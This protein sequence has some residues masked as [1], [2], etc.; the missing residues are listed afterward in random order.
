LK[1]NYDKGCLPGVDGATAVST[2]PNRQVVGRSIMAYGDDEV[3]YCGNC[4]RQQEPSRG[5]KCV[6]CGKLTVSWFTN[7][8]SETD[9]LRKWKTVNG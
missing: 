5:E 3:Y 2:N 8:E 4:R 9:A 7:R 6:Q 1:N